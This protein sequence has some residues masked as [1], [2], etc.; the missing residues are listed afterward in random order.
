MAVD[1]RKEAQKRADRIALFRTELAE[2]EREKGLIL[3]A[4]HR[5]HLEDHLDRLLFGFRRQFGVDATDSARRVSWGMRVASL[6][7][8]AALLAATV[9]FLHREDPALCGE[10]GTGSPSVAGTLSEPSTTHYLPRYRETWFPAPRYAG[11]RFF[12]L[13]SP[14]G[15]D[16]K[17]KSGRGVCPPAA[18]SRAPRV[19]PDRFRSTG[20][21]PTQGTAI[22]GARLLGREL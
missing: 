21:Q 11:W 17:P 22:C 10:C 6:L 1:P 9:L 7:G 20:R 18:E 14:R 2:L 16:T 13:A 4:E 5:S 15:V 8:G 3:S 12:E 19:A